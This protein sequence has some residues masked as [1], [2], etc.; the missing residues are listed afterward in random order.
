MRAF[1]YV[2]Q[3]FFGSVVAGFFQSEIEGGVTGFFFD[4]VPWTWWKENSQL[5]NAR[6][7]LPN[8]WRLCV[9]CPQSRTPDVRHKSTSGIYVQPEARRKL[10]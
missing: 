7:P 1:K 8:T 10:K 5:R 6:H 3:R 4:V 2:P 9:R